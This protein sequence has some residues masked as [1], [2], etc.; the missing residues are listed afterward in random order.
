MAKQTVLFDEINPYHYGD[1]RRKQP[2]ILPKVLEAAA[3]KFAF[4]EDQQKEAHE[5]IKKWADME[6]EG[7]L[8][9]MK[10]TSLQGEF[11]SDVFGKA[12]R[13]IRVSDN[14]D[15]WELQEHISLPGGQD[16]DAALGFFSRDGQNKPVV[17]VELKRPNVNVDRKGSSG[18]TPVLQCWDYLYL[19][20]ECPWGIV[21]N[22]VSFRL[23]HREHTPNSYEL[24][25]L[26]ELRDEY[27]FRQF[28][29]LFDHDALL[30][31]IFTQVPRALRLLRQ[32]QE[33]QKEVG[34]ELYRHYHDSRL[35][36]IDHLQREPYAKT[37]DSAIQ[38]AQ[39]L[40]DRIIFIA[41]C[42]DRGLL[43]HKTI[44]KAY[45]HETAFGL[46]TNPKWRNFLNLFQS[47]DK[48]NERAGIPRYNGGLFAHNADVD[49]LD[50]DD[51][52]TTFFRQIST[53][54]FQDEVNVDVLGHIFEQS[55]TD[56]EVLRAD[57]D[58]VLGK[59]KAQRIGK[60][61]REGVYYTPPS[62]TRY[63][64]ER[65]LGPC[66]QKRFADIA[67][68]HKINPE[69]EPTKKNLS[70]WL[71]CHE[72]M[73]ESLKTLRVCDPACGSGAFLIQA[74][75]YLEDRYRELVDAIC[76]HGDRTQNVLWNDA[77]QAILNENLHGV[78][79]SAESVEIARL[80]L[81][82]RSAERGKTLANLSHNIVCGNSIVEDG[83]VDPRAL[84]WKETFPDVFSEGGFDCVISNP[85][86]VKLQNFRKT[87]PRIAA[88]LT[89]RYRSAQ[90]GNFDMYLPF[91][92][93]GLEILNDEGRLG[94]IAPSVWLFNE[95]GRG[96]RELVLE[97]R[98]LEHF[99]DFKS[100]QVFEDATTYTAL[101]FFHK[102]TADTI[103]V[104]SAPDGEPDAHQS[105]QVS[106]DHLDSGAWA[107]LPE[108]NQSIFDTMNRNSIPLS[109]ASAGII[110]G[111]Q[112]SADLIYHVTRLGE[113]KFYSH[114]LE[115]VVELE[116]EIMKPLI[117]G[118]EAILF[119]TPPTDKFL[120]FPYLV[121]AEECRLFTEAEMK[122]KFR[123][124]WDYLKQHE[125]ELR[126]RERG[127][128]DHEKWYGYNYPKNI[129]K[130]QLP[131]IGIPQTVSH[132][133]AFF[134]HQ[135]ERYF[136]NVRVNGILEREDKAFSLWFI[137]GICNSR[138]VDFAFRQTAK[139]K[140]RGYF[141]A[142]KQ[143]I[144]PLPVPNVDEKKQKPI[145]G[146]AEKLSGLYAKREAALRKVHYRIALDLAPRTL[147]QAS[148]I[149]PT[150]PRKLQQFETTSPG[151]RF[152]A[153]ETFAKRKLSPTER[154][155]WDQYLSAEINEMA[156]VKRDIENR[157]RE[158][159]EKVYS[160]YGLGPEDIQVIEE[161]I[162]SA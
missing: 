42:E 119:A 141:E 28:L 82:I 4:L 48:G 103:Q 77:K 21:C 39:T 109:E 50:L 29:T 86:Y 32:S 52:W 79:L 131:K 83:D 18:R 2:L 65:T 14:Q 139:P 84:D 57:P 106:Y 97:N 22:Y 95:Y 137:L 124:A 115:D 156:K 6:S 58:V 27:R 61:K 130:Q 142:N 143:F 145:A 98:S 19:V 149:T 113:G 128:M 45:E 10:E 36:L 144:A 9:N 59:P 122:K 123:R 133:S 159:N 121:T 44:Q 85:P 15:H 69:M 23:Y 157:T 138:A 87:S 146:I 100:F 92:E 41:F 158:L 62:I 116:E 111:I 117:S 54:D 96:L 1:N 108:S 136:N 107:L 112:T 105:Y 68:K 47:I 151:E 70:S 30:H 155:T 46:V 161:Q 91:I 38:S 132:L 63:I 93:H 43:P 74:Y 118:E 89:R 3:Q 17:I 75:D 140:D 73:L 55:I 120:L 64:V 60:R 76:R 49:D 35:D 126:A 81:W 88:F 33:R 101:Q 152:K 153:M 135:G 99:V 94:F 125:T 127:K 31:P 53:Y 154:D 110:V 104:V 160:L 20:P 134:D 66:I 162:H 26:Q 72:E 13:Y 24:F 129:D 80:A 40:L 25:T 78:D 56:L 16:A 147:L 102:T 148:P 67:Q 12:L 150:L 34:K 11:L 71:T 90:T 7:K 8:E 5:I 37:L 114:S 51:R